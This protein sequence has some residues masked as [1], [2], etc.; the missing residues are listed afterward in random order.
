MCLPGLM[1]APSLGK[2]S[3]V[4]MVD[5]NMM[6]PASSRLASRLMISSSVTGRDSLVRTPEGELRDAAMAAAAFLSN[7]MIDGM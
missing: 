6:S 1:G 5:C 2:S 7:C 3:A 4:G